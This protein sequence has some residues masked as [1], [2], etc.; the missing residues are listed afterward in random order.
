MNSAAN[1]AVT[2]AIAT[3]RRVLIGDQHPAAMLDPGGRGLLGVGDREVRT[4]SA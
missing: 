3:E 4:H 1:G 2:A